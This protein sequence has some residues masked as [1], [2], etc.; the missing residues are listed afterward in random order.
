M[1]D[2]KVVTLNVR[3]IRSVVKRR[4]LFRFF[5]KEYPNHIVALQETHSSASDARYWESEWGDQILFG[6]NG[7]SNCESGVAILFPRTLRGICTT[8]VVYSSEDG[9]MLIAELTFEKLT[10]TVIVIYAPTQRHSRQQFKFFQMLRDVIQN[11]GLMQIERLLLLGD[12]NVHLT[13][14][15]IMSNRFQLTSSAKLLCEILKDS[16]LIDVWRASHKELVRYTWRQSNPLRQSRIDYIF[17][18]EN[19][20]NSHCLKRIDIK[21]SILTDHSIVNFE[22]TLFSS[23]KGP[24]LFRF[25]NDLLLDNS[26]VEAAKLEIET[27]MAGRDMYRDIDDPGLKLETLSGQIRALCLKRKK[28]ICRQKKEQRIATFREL[29]QCERE[30]SA[31]PNDD[32]AARY[33]ELKNKI[34]EMEEEKGKKAMLYSGARWIEKGERPTKYFLGLGASREIKKQIN[35]LQDGNDELITGNS[36]ILHYC[37]NYFKQLYSS[38]ATVTTAKLQMECFWENFNFPTLS[39]EEKAMCEG[40]LTAD[41]CKFALNGMM[42]NKSPSVSGFGKEFFHFFWTELEPIVVSYINHAKVDGQF[43]ITQ[44]RGIITLIPKK[45]RDQKRIRNKRAICLLDI[46][47][48]IVAKALA[49]RLMR[50]IRA[51]VAED[52]TGAIRGRYIGTNLRTVADAIA[53]CEMDRLDGIIMALDFE[54]AFNTVEHQFIYRV[55]RKFN[56]GDDFIDWVKLLYNG[57]ELAII[58]NGFTSDWF[59]PM[60]GL[61]QGCPLSAP[62]F[63]LIVESLAIRLRTES[64]VHGISVAGTELKISQYIDDTTIYV[65]DEK[66]ACKAINIVHDFG[67]ISGLKLNMDKCE[68]MWLGAKKHCSSRICGQPPVERVKILGVI[69]SAIH[70]CEADNIRQAEGK[71]HAKLNQWSQRDLTLKG[72]ITVAKSLLVSQLTYLMTSMPIENKHLNSIQSK[73]MKFLWRGRPPKVAKNTLYQ[74]I[75]SGGLNL[76]N[77]IAS[78]K[79][80]RASWVGKI[81]GNSELAFAK[82]FKAKIRVE[83]RDLAK[84]NFSKAWVTTRKIPQFYKEM[85]M[86]FR[87]SIPL[88]EPRTGKEVR[89]Q[90]IWNNASI[91]VQGK[92]VFCR[93]LYNEGVKLID[94]FLDDSGRI[95]DYRNFRQRFPAAR[96]GPLRYMGWCQAIPAQWRSKAA[97]S[98]SLS[99]TERVVTPTLEIKGR[100]I[101][102]QRVRTKYFYTKWI[103]AITPT[104]Q[105]KW[106]N[107]GI[108]FE[109]DWSKIYQLPFKITNS[110]RLQNLQYRITQRFFP[111]RRFLCI[112]NVISDPFCNECGEIE[113]TEHFFAE[114]HSVSDFWNR[115]MGRLNTRL[116]L[117]HRFNME[118]KNIVF[119]LIGTKNIV[120]FIALNAKQFIVNQ[121]FRDCEISVDGFIHYIQRVYDTEKIIAKN[122]DKMDSFIERWKP[123]LSEAHEFAF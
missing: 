88:N 69:F 14:K 99:P 26:F 54:N 81:I 52:Q 59:T 6:H 116:N 51:L 115:L 85:L 13:E 106:E 112:R 110:T 60:R 58:N 20:C 5:H 49:N 15:D 22:M 114:C 122:N 55:L 104:S 10:L 101:L 56:F 46:V 118:T 30:L 32:I 80:L 87:E 19:L 17:A 93:A 78:N 62:L 91:R 3:G 8:K 4:A 102:V 25:W 43:F 109:E 95:L 40:P 71:I 77:L 84:M 113:T 39:E 82:I 21:P 57:T 42:N 120:N 33:S 66:S 28:E 63:A 37:R 16:N 117:R 31:H 107:E 76:P 36:E 98:H 64:D 29:D 108:N 12:F 50:V 24:G 38:V 44:R 97:G 34:N 100:D 35:V 11:V 123:F 83:L 103:N 70:S 94:D 7:N 23:G 86:W 65:Q 67:K 48:K 90:L 72:K 2:V 74:G 27:A 111:T 45:N 41:E 9:R 105:I 68:F 47:Y 96:I 121:R 18:S 61:Q 119:G 53:Y 79:A 75:E 73:I 89:K 1:P 92:S